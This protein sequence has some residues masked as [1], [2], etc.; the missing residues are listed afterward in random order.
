M[1]ISCVVPY[2]SGRFSINNLAVRNMYISS[3]PHWH[4]AQLRA[5]SKPKPMLYCGK[6]ITE[7][8]EACGQHLVQKR[9]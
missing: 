1:F 6:S 8:G 4:N 3:S 9:T 5:T 2:R 7:C